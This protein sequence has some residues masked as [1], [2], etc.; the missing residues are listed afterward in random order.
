MYLV[1]PVCL[2]IAP[3]AG[4]LS[5][6]L[7][8][9][10]AGLAVVGGLGL[11]PDRVAAAEVA[12]A[13]ENEAEVPAGHSYHGEAF[14]E[15]PRQAARL[16]GGTGKV[17]FPVSSTE[18]KVQ[19]F[20]DQGVGQL[21]G[22]WYFEAERSFR[23]AAA[24]DPECAIAY[25]GMAMANINNEPR[26]REFLKS[27]TKLKGQIDD[28]ERMWVESL[29]TFYGQAKRKDVER[30]GQY[31]R[32]LED[33]VHA[34]PDDLEAKAFLACQIWH[35]DAK[36]LPITSHE[37]VDALI[38]QVLAA[39]PMHPAHHYRIHLWDEEKPGRA[40]ASAA[41]CGP[42]APHIAHMWHMPGH[43]Y[44]R[45]HRYADA[46]WQQEASARVDHAHLAEF[47]VFPDQIHNY[48]HNQEWLIR[49]LNFVGRAHTAV[50]LAKNLIGLPRHPAINPPSGKGSAHFGPLR[51][52]ET[53]ERYE[54]WDEA[55]SA[56]DEGYLDKHDDPKIEAKRLSV[57]AAANFQLERTERGIALVQQLEQLAK[58]DRQ[59]VAPPG[60]DKL[61][62]E[63]KKPD[64]RKKPEDE[65]PPVDQQAIA[66]ADQ[67]EAAKDGRK[68]G[69]SAVK[70]RRDLEAILEHTRGYQS[71]AGGNPRQALAHFEKGKRAGKL[72]LSRVHL[73]AGNPGKAEQLA[74]EA[75]AAGPGEFLPAAW[76]A[77]LLFRL[78]RRHDALKAFERV[79]ELGADADLDL[80][81]CHRLA[82]FT[83]D[84][85]LP[86]D[87]RYEPETA[88]DLGQRPAAEKLGPLTFTPFRADD[89]E[90]TDVAG[91]QVRLSD[92]RGRPVVLLLYLGMGCVH[93]VE[94]L[95]AFGP[96]KDEFAE[97]DIKLVAIGTDPIE[98]TAESLA[99]DPER[100]KQ[101]PFPLLADP[102]LTVF[103][104]YLAIDDFEHKPMHAT[105]LVDGEGFIRWQDI[106]Y[107]PFVD[108]RFVLKES[109]RLL[110]LGAARRTVLRLS[111][112]DMK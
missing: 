95:K 91:K 2:R 19:E 24:L 110:G 5:V 8:F 77:E 79:R 44:S 70:L 85:D 105:I 92:Y 99:A 97:S 83:P 86:E 106:G 41:L 33:I 16:L 72:L 43:I 23:Q 37:A 32:A 62:I 76:H 47:H 61:V 34:Y 102:K 55:I 59:P 54:L 58:Q 53:L 46:A 21:H 25:W 109:R 7:G 9:V 94:Q 45:L 63:A 22:F 28:R 50:A 101:I 35:N 12:A 71:L 31:V 78:D 20:I 57:L 17:S 98:D 48:A 90:L 104:R 14:N 42:A 26:A 96:L 112:L 67:P 93:C 73:A 88:D 75:S 87:W 100:A 39:E 80:P 108:A 3:N 107:E 29:E 103:K 84:Y 89:W 13:E 65:K 11:P 52:L 74:R 51:L 82:K 38:G 36:G 111:P 1:P 18:P 49:D 64:N 6:W 56:E 81:V 68:K 15:G 69:E 30:R 27:A 40:L 4:A 60:D 10:V 66:R